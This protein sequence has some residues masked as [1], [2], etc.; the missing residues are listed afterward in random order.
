MSFKHDDERRQQMAELGWEVAI[1]VVDRDNK[2]ITRVG[3]RYVGEVTEDH[4]PDTDALPRD[5]APK[6]P[7]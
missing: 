7:E 4:D 2:Q 5:Q 3:Y 1:I 6:Q